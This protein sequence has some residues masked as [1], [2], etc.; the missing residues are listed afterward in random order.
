MFQQ[1]QAIKLKVET[2]SADKNASPNIPND[3]SP[4]IFKGNVLTQRKTKEVEQQVS[5]K[6]NSH[7]FFFV[8]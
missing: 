8:L 4:N 1:I 7:Y 2:S 5:I 6:L 3:K